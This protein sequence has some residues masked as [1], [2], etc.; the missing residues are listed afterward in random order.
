MLLHVVSLNAVLFLWQASMRGIPLMGGL[1][2][3]YQTI[4][5]SKESISRGKPSGAQTASPS[6]S[7]SPGRS[8]LRS[9]VLLTMTCILLPAQDQQL[10]QTAWQPTAH[11]QLHRTQR[12]RRMAW[13]TT[14]YQLR[15]QYRTQR[16]RQMAWQTTPYQL[17]QQTQ[18]MRQQKA[19][20]Q[21]HSAATESG[22]SPRL[23]LSC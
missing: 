3:A 16:H 19:L 1:L 12:L 20:Q 15:Q 9:A 13:Q 14:P 10:R 21:Q 8:Q 23:L 5:A 7:M 18:R 4:W 11:Q 2:K 22:A 6:I 17:R